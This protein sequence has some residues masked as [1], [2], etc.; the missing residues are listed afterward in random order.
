ML[1]ADFEIKKSIDEGSLVI[2]NFSEKQ[3]QGASYDIRIGKEVM[4]SNKELVINMED[5][6][7]AKI[8]P[9]EFALISTHEYFEIPKDIAGNIGG[10]TY[11]TRRGL[12]PLTGLQI[13]PGF[14]GILAIGVFNS[15]PKNIIIEYL[16]SFCT[17][18]FFK[19]SAPA[20]KS[21]EPSRFQ[22]DLI[23][24]KLPRV[25]I[26]F[27]RDLETGSLTDVGKELRKVTQT[28]GSLAS[29]TKIFSNILYFVII[30]LFVLTLLAV[31]GIYGIVFYTH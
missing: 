17:I 12:I 20:K 21:F 30:P 16:E 31:F 27:F 24:G 13:D 25:D 11:F 28:V 22:E 26:D 9:G 10:K 15:S 7:T 2:K 19:L 5:K 18:Q 6:S 8:E 23:E 14:K 3:L 29:S 1:M 4:I